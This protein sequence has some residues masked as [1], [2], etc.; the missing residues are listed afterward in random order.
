MTPLMLAA[1]YDDPEL[2]HL[3]LSA[4]ARIN[5]ADSSGQTALSYACYAGS[6]IATQELLARRCA[7]NVRDSRGITPLMEAAMWGHVEQCRLL[8][9]SGADPT[10]RDNR[11]NGAAAHVAYCGDPKGVRTFLGLLSKEQLARCRR[12]LKRGA[13]IA[14]RRAARNAP[15]EMESAKRYRR[16][17]QVF[18]QSLDK[19]AKSGAPE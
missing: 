2:L 10:L 6:M 13:G 4:G 16:I 1:R 19:Q 15:H 3:A 7:V 11:G 5:E 18:A 9:A 17:Q 14:R 8:L 12:D